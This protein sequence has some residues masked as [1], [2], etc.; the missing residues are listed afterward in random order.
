MD[1]RY[2]KAGIGDIPTMIA[3]RFEF[4]AALGEKLDDHVAQQLRTNLQRYFHDA[5][6]DQTLICWYAMEGNT[7]A[8]MGAI[9][10]RHQYPTG[11]NL[12]GKVGYVFSMFTRAD[13][14]KRGIASTILNKL[15]DSAHEQGITA[16]ELHATKEG[17]PVY[18]NN[19]FKIHGE[20]TLRKFL[21]LP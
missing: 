19:G 4:A 2:I 1:I 15:V 18:V 3:L 11:K 8:G 14:R 13:Y 10:I 5:L 16:F 9:N 20:P 21:Q 6:Q 12:S 7:P 17:E